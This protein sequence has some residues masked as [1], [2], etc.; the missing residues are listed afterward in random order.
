MGPAALDEVDGNCNS[1]W[2][3]VNVLT[4]VGSMAEMLN[5]DGI[6]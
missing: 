1:S 5:P 3:A 6:G 2:P 4:I